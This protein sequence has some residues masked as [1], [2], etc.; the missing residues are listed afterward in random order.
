[1]AR[2]LDASRF[3]LKDWLFAAAPAIDGGKATPTYFG[4]SMDG[5]VALR[6]HLFSFAG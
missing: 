4:R 5:Q 3:R 6:F 1:M 2:A